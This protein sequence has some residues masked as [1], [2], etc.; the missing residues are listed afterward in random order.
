MAANTSNFRIKYEKKSFDLCVPLEIS[1]DNLIKI[2]EQTTQC[3]ARPKLIF[4]GTLLRTDE[5]IRQFF[6]LASNVKKPVT[7]LVLGGHSRGNEVAQYEQ[8][9]LANSVRIWH[10]TSYDLVAYYGYHYDEQTDT[11]LPPEKDHR[12]DE[13]SPLCSP[14]SPDTVFSSGFP[15][16][17]SQESCIQDLIVRIG[18]D[19]IE[20]MHR[21]AFMLYSGVNG[22]QRD[23][24]QAAVYF[25]RAAEAG[26]AEAMYYLGHCYRD[27]KGVLQ[28]KKTALIWYKKACEHTKA[29]SSVGQNERL[30]L[31]A[32]HCVAFMEEYLQGS[33]FSH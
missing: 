19:E 28:D 23:V 25:T 16:E 6:Q 14:T 15:L 22:V 31:L 13:D 12:D 30:H 21:Y 32:L 10:E 24:I 27:G 5:Q 9:V 33:I 8:E 29:G 2:V 17:P 20:A 1:F 3:S 18:D 7:V 11:F 4:F 26:W